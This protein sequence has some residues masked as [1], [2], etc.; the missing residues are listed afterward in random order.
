MSSENR[1][2]PG[3]EEID[4]SPVSYFPPGGDKY[5]G[6]LTITNRRLIYEGTFNARLRHVTD[7]AAS[8]KCDSEGRLE[9]DRRAIRK[10][11]VNNQGLTRRCVLLLKDRSRHAFDYGEKP[12][13]NVVAELQGAHR[14]RADAKPGSLGLRLLKIVIYAIL[15]VIVSDI[16]GAVVCT[17]LDLVFPLFTSQVLFYTLWIVLG[18]F[19]GLFIHGISGAGASPGSDSNWSDRPDAVRTGT[20]VCAATLPVLVGLAWACWRLD[21]SGDSMYVPDN[22]ALSITY[23]IAISIGVGFAQL[24]IAQ[25]VKSKS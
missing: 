3:E 9:I 16:A 1:L 11:E 10:L 15:L 13:D 17:V 23:F 21:G 22:P 14:K 2:Q 5:K 8:V 6:T 19:T 20:L 7:L 24:M 25:P 4:V 12:I 18:F